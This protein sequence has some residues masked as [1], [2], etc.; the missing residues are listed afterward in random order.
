MKKKIIIIGG[1]ITGCM[2]A[3]YIDKKNFDVSIY[4]SKNN[5]GGVLSDF[6][7]KDESFLNGVQYLDVNTDWYI[8]IEKLF[9][10]KLNK[11]NHSYGSITESENSISFSDKFAVPVF[12][13]IELNSLKKLKK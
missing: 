5:L 2:A 6:S 8:E 7:H 11:F 12:N 3:L 4:E 9:R 13:N 1:G 10:K